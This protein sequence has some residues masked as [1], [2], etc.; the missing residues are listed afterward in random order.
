MISRRTIVGAG[1]GLGAVGVLAAGA[2]GLPVLGSAFATGSPWTRLREKLTG[3]LVLPSDANYAV[4]KQLQL[5]Q[6]DVIAPQAIAYCETG[7]D[8]A[9]CVRFAQDQHLAATARSGGHSFAGYS[10][11]PGL[12]IDVSRLN[13]VRTGR[14]T[15]RLGPGCQGVDV[16]TALDPYGIQV[17]GGTCPTV[18][19]GGWLLGGGLGPH[20]RKFGMG[21]DRLVSAQ[22][23]L[24]DGTLKRCSEHE[25]ADLFWALRGGGGGNFGI[26]TE[27][28]VRPTQLP[29]MV[30]FSLV[31]PWAAAADTIQAWQRWI[32]SGARE[33][34]AELFVQLSTDDPAGTEPTVQVSGTYAGTSA[35]CDLAVGKLLAAVGHQP[36]SREA[37]EL[38]YR[39]GMMKVF[40]CADKSVPQCHRVGYSPQAQLPRDNFVTGRNLYFTGP[41]TRQAT[42]EALAAFG[43][44][45]Q[46]GQYRFLGFFAYGGQINTVDPKATAFVHRDVLFET[47][48]Q[49]GLTT[50]APAQPAKDAA[51]AWV[52]G[53]YAALDPYSNHRSYQ[54]YMDPALR[55]WREAYYGQNYARL[56]SVKRTYDPHGFFRFAQGID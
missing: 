37:T 12:V 32:A 24:A 13:G 45:I 39:A 1:A 26:V 48:Y 14:S 22:V 3:D 42:Q 9:A 19:A 43:A 30:V 36:V 55:N 8:V 16:V 56:R 52:N 7:A 15:V 46:K 41:W 29:S 54:N 40:G 23:V 35:E 4:A 20:A 51:Q 49:I 33:L 25:N 6:Y 5:S 10:T 21:C 2:A 47:D 31:F 17:A 44:D 18:A 53:G 50:P 34:A 11:T 27:Y 28:E 38:P